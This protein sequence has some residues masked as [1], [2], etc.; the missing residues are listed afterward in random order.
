[1][2]VVPSLDATNFLVE[3]RA[4]GTAAILAWAA[5]EIVQHDPDGVMISLHS[6]HAIQPAE[7]FRA[8]LSTAA[9][10]SRAAG[11]SWQASVPAASEARSRLAREIF[12]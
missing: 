10:E 12:S 3:P 7:S 11:R 8:L 1:M 9:V 4:R 6:D 5:H 2:S